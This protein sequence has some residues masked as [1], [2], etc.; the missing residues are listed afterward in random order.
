MANNRLEAFGSDHDFT[1]TDVPTDWNEKKDIEEFIDR[2][3]EEDGDLYEHALVEIE[4][5]RAKLDEA[6]SE[7]LTTL[8]RPRGKLP[9]DAIEHLTIPA[10]ISLARQA[11]AIKD[12]SPSSLERLSE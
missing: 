5:G 12:F 8:F 2:F 6:L 1:P 7:L 10:K 4:R 3:D 9:F 11:P